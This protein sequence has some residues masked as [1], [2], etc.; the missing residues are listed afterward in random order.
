MTTRSHITSLIKITFSVLAVL[1]I[2]ATSTL[3]QSPPTPDNIFTNP[4]STA[5]ATAANWSNGVPT[6][7]DNALIDDGLT[8]DASS[9]AFAS[10]TL[11]V[12]ARLNTSTVFPS[13]SDIYFSDASYLDWNTGNGSADWFILPG[14]NAT[15]TMPNDRLPGGTLQGAGNLAVLLEGNIFWQKNSSS[16]TGNLTFLSND[17]SSARS[18]SM[19]GNV[20]SATN[21]LE[22]FVN[23][24]LDNNNTMPDSSTLK[25]VGESGAN[26]P[27]M[28]MEHKDGHDR[29]DTI[30]NLLV[31]SPVG[32]TGS[33]PLFKATDSNNKLTVTDTVTFQGTAATVELDDKTP[34]SAGLLTSNMTFTGT[35]SWTVQGDCIIEFTGSTLTTT[36]NATIRSPLSGDITKVGSATL[37]LDNAAPTYSDT[38]TVSEGALSYTNSSAV[39][40]FGTISVTNTGTIALDYTGTGT[41]IYLYFDG[42]LAAS[43]VWGSPTSGAPNTTNLI[44]GTGFLKNNIGAVDNLFY[45]DGGDTN[46]PANGDLVSDGGNGTWNTTTQ[47]WDIGYVAH[48]AWGNTTDDEA[49]FASPP[50]TVTLGEDITIKTLTINDVTAANQYTIRSNTLGFASGGTIEVNSSQGG[51]WNTVTT[52]E[53]AITGTPTIVLN[54]G[55]NTETAFAPTEGSQQL[56]AQTGAGLIALGGTTTSN[57][58]ASAAA[59]TRWEGTGASEWT[60]TGLASAYEHF[61]ESGALILSG[62]GSLR[63]NNRAVKHSGGVLHLNNAAAIFCDATGVPGNNDT[64]DTLSLR[65]GDLDNS[66]GAPVTLASTQPPR[67][68]WSSDWT[69]LGSQ[70][71]NS[72]L[73]FGSGAVVLFA[74]PTVTINSNATFTVGGPISGAY[75]LTKAGTGTL[76][77]TGANTYSGHTTVNAGTQHITQAYLADGAA[78]I[79]SGSGVLN[80]D[81]VGTDTVSVFKTNGV[82]TAAGEWGGPGS[83]AANTSP[84]LAGTGKLLVSNGDGSALTTYWDGPNSG[85]TGN[86]ASD[87]GTAT[88]N[89]ST[90]N[91]DQFAGESRVVWPNTTDTPAVF[92]GVNVDYTVTIAEP[93]NVGDLTI[94]MTGDEDEYTFN[95]AA[96][97]F[98]TGATIRVSDNRSDQTFTCAITGSPDVETKD[99]GA[100][101]QYQGIKFAPTNGTVTLGDVLNPNNSGNT[102]KAGFKMA[103]STTGNSVNSIDYAASDRYGTVYCEGGE[104]TVGYIRTGTVR[105]S[106]GTLIANG[107]VSAGYQNFIFTG[108]TLAG[109]GVVDEAI[110]APAAGM[111]APGDPTGT[112]TITNN[113]CDIDG[114]LAI[115]IA[116]AQVGTLAM[117]PDNTLDITGATLDVTGAGTGYGE[118]VI[119]T[120]GDASKLLGEP[121][122]STNGLPDD[123]YVE[124]DYNSD[125]AIAIVIPPPAGTIFLLR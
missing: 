102:D 74:S 116:G 83:G 95:G 26:R 63:S 110:S 64:G 59:K 30:A 73:D 37:T 62:S 61:I 22:D 5:W 23:G 35:G 84:A 38:I 2:A 36:T 16:L 125:T 79:V 104:W 20:G 98:G 14:A 120:Y 101:N 19:R 17:G 3:A 85:G 72:D 117:D 49:V 27:K 111:I 109:T 42:S 54:M 124:Y 33:K 13:G 78:V 60:L 88:W 97:T 7:S 10:L 122:S 100:G 50:G 48:A 68:S 67:M 40:P 12:G 99:Q 44:S 46:N 24:L 103:G 118:F 107:N 119:A 94:T 90:D 87:G 31:E 53:S 11:G 34:D 39:S 113:N 52:I 108:G 58:L 93:L 75:N 41:T 91:W 15:N 76:K 43:G 66:S 106:G 47:N 6:A 51:N 55:G 32:L 1:A 77:L 70:G 4:A 92:W 29:N 81:F 69:F 115:T 114:T 28:S 56:G 112:L 80:L 123:A 8:V 9:V 45:W 82:F 25:L 89:T 65:G 21:V 105:L 71:S 86:G 57:T 96:L 121:F 18:L